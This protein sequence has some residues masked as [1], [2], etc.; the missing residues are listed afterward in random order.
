MKLCRPPVGPQPQSSVN[1]VASTHG[2]IPGSYTP[3]PTST[4]SSNTAAIQVLTAKDQSSVIS[5]ALHTAKMA[6]PKQ[7]HQQED[8]NDQKGLFKIWHQVERAS[9]EASAQL[10]FFI[11]TRTRPR[12]P[13][14]Q[15]RRW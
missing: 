7:T 12:T 8:S 10:A 4:S 9:T 5:E 11:P 1:P 13:L 15:R 3:Q 2:T 14:R 6:K